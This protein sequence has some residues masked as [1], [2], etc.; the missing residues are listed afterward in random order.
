MHACGC[1]GPCRCERTGECICTVVCAKLEGEEI[2]FSARA[3]RER[4]KR[5][6]RR[7]D[8]TSLRKEFRSNDDD[9][10]VMRMPGVLSSVERT[11]PCWLLEGEP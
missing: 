8:P 2:V 10:V 3:S 5:P 7:V 1:L 4:E 9:G 6:I 11:D